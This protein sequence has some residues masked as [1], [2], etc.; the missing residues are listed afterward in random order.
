M[1]ENKQPFTGETS[2]EEYCSDCV[3][4]DCCTV[5]LKDGE[6]CGD[7]AV[8]VDQFEGEPPYIMAAD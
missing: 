2:Q 4:R 6:L 5:M 7:Y 3:F 8:D 1:S